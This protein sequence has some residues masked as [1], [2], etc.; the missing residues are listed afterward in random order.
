MRARRRVLGAHA[1][2]Q[3]LATLAEIFE[4]D[5]DVL[6][7][8]VRSA[9]RRRVRIEV[10]APGYGLPRSATYEYEEWYRGTAG[11]W[12]LTDYQYEVR[13]GPPPSGR[14]AY[15]WHDDFFHFHCEDSGGPEAVDHYRGYVVDLLE[16]ARP[17]FLA[18]HALGR[19]DC[20]GLHPL[21]RRG[22]DIAR[23]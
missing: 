7:D 11:G 12:T 13:L 4:T 1:F 6:V 23:A 17:D 18:I 19:V 2:E 20:S 15:H 3:R 9:R 5:G 22:R 21:R 14:K 8:D 10:E 16:D